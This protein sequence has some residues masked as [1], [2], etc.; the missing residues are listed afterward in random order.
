MVLLEIYSHPVVTR[1]KS[2]ICSKAT[3]YALVALVL[4]FIPPLLIAFR[5]KGFWMT[6][7]TYMEQPD[8]QFKKQAL[9]LL[10]T[11][12]AGS[13]LAWSTYTN[14]NNII[15]DVYRVSSVSS[16]EMD[17]NGDGKYDSLNF[18]VQVPLASTEDISSVQ[19]LLIFDYKLKR[20]SHL[21]M[22]GAAYVQFASLSPGSSF[23]TFG[24]LK[25]VQKIPL[26]SRGVDNRYNSSIVNSSSVFAP[27][28]D[29][30]NILASYAS[31]NISTRFENDYPVWKSGRGASQPFTV[32][33]IVQY[34]TETIV[35]QPGFWELIKWGWVQYVSIL[36]LFL[37]IFERINTA[38]FNSQFL[39]CVV[40]SPKVKPE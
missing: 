33:V 5:S 10:D 12:T 38:L 3:L 17:S 31:R 14:F 16:T 34:P 11:P 21:Q 35:Y 37:W 27:D 24:D 23:T 13:Y 36:L 2:S 22:E 20:Y 18:T 29:I 6:T 9:M 40:E 32:T 28:Y 25:L 4:T 19:L 30:T 8:V 7:N 26:L 15:Q 1:Y 39:H